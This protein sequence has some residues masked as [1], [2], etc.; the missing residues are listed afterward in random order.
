MN[1]IP[2]LQR[3]LG[4]DWQKLP[5]VI[6][7]HYQLS[8]T[9]SSCT[10]VNGTMRINYPTFIKP[11]LVIARLMGALIDLKGEGMQVSVKK[12]VTD[13]SSTLY[14]RRTIQA[15][16]GRGTVFAS[17]MEY[18]HGNQLIEF[19]GFGFGIRLN[20]FAENKQLVYR[21]N[22]HLWRCGFVT[23]PIPDILFLGHATIIERPIDDDK[24]VLDFKI[25]HPL[26]GQTYEYGGVFS[27]E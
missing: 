24:F 25:N 21:S 13:S 2:L 6:Q 3:A 12:W 20:V 17:R 7:R 10:V 14:W 9:E 22:G 4:D 27:Y 1:K 8:D 16:D 11:V 19:V 26:F 18:Q 23:I 5:P 15:P